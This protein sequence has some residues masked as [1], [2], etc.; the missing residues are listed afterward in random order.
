MRHIYLFLLVIVISATTASAQNAPSLPGEMVPY[1]VISCAIGN[2]YTNHGVLWTGGDC[3]WIRTNTNT[4]LYLDNWLGEYSPS[5][6]LA[7]A[8]GETNYLKMVTENP[9]GNTRKYKVNVVH[10]PTARLWWCKRM[11]Y[12]TNEIGMTGSDFRVWSVWEGSAQP[13]MYTYAP[14]KIGP[15]WQY[16]T[17]TTHIYNKEPEHLLFRLATNGNPAYAKAPNQSYS[18]N[19]IYI[20]MAN[21]TDVTA[22]VTRNNILVNFSAPKAEIYNFGG[23]GLICNSPYITNPVNRPG[24]VTA[25]L[26]Y[27]NHTVTVAAQPYTYFVKADEIGYWYYSG[28]K[29]LAGYSAYQ[30][31]WIGAGA[32]W[33]EMPRTITTY[34]MQKETAGG[35]LTGT[36]TSSITE[37]ATS[38]RW[39]VSSGGDYS[40]SSQMTLTFDPW[41]TT[42]GTTF[43]QRG[44]DGTVIT[45]TATN[46]QP[47][48]QNVIQG[49]GNE[50]DYGIIA[51]GY[52]QFEALPRDVAQVR[53]YMVPGQYTSISGL[54]L[55]TDG[56]IRG[57][58]D[59]T[60]FNTNYNQ[61]DADVTYNQGID[62]NGRMYYNK[63]VPYFNIQ[64]GVQPAYSFYA[65]VSY[66]DP[67][68]APT[69][70][71]LNFSASITTGIDDEPQALLTTD[72]DAEPRHY[73]LQGRPIDPTTPGLHLI[74]HADGT[75]TK[76]VVR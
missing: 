39:D 55:N 1:S 47:T 8:Q 10:A 12:S 46:A 63:A 23:L 28:T 67:A 6:T 5:Y 30:C 66:R 35:D 57:S 71:G 41:G 20:Y 15:V 40:Y 11:A 33:E 49:Y 62:L 60:N 59:I 4:G 74:R 16:V 29:T 2:H 50:S 27:T 7:T 45:T 22:G 43:T 48:S 14:K 34:S 56:T 25:N 19:I 53:L 17:D 51:R 37:P 76:A 42:D 72:N 54:T 70:H 3:K 73:D 18:G 13:C 38:N 21:A 24:Y 68:V 75:T 44:T 64:G 61:P 31:Y 65:K 58:M 26:N 36:F 9:S 52:I 69:Y 32:E